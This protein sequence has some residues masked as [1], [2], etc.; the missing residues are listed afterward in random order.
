MKNF[1]NIQN[2]K[3]ALGLIT[4][5]LI[6]DYFVYGEIDWYR[7]IGTSILAVII[8]AIFGGRKK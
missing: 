6:F 3:T 1:F 5:F 7:T 8:M 2:L 4:G